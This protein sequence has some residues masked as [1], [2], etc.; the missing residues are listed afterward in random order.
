[1]SAS[2]EARDAAGE[3][4]MPFGKFKGKTIDEIASS[5]DGLRWLDW[6]AGAISPGSAKTMIETY[7]D[8]PVIQREIQEA[9]DDYDEERRFER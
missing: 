9:I 6:A 4:V 3:Y 2:E 5:K 7:L 1:M 8:N